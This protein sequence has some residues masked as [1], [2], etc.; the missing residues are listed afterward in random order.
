MVGGLKAVERR[1]LVVY[2]RGESVED[3]AYEKGVCRGDGCMAG[4][5][6]ARIAGTFTYPPNFGR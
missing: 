4:A 3:S 5:V 1:Y 2:N 6:R